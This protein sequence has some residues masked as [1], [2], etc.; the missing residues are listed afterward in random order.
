VCYGVSFECAAAVTVLL[1]SSTS[2]V[3]NMM[4]VIPLLQLAS[5]TAAQQ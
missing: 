5:I 2:I 3:T 1:L 4:V